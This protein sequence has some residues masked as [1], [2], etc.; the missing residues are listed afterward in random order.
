MF[1][2]GCLISVFDV[3]TSA[4]CI[5]EYVNKE[6]SIPKYD[7]IFV[8]AGTDSNSRRYDIDKLHIEDKNLLNLNSG[9]DIGVITV[10][11]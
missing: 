9:N 4:K 11:P 10:R 3:I 8:V 7:G 6:T 1:G 2:V 5:E